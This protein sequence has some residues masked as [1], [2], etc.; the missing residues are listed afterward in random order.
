ML[1]LCKKT[2]K[3]LFSEHLF[4]NDEI[5][6]AWYVIGEA[7]VGVVTLLFQLVSESVYKD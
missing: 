3:G 1:T 2:K 5:C 6:T 4:T 7:T